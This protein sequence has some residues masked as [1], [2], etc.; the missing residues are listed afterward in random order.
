M[1]MQL[2]LDIYCSKKIKEVV[3]FVGYSQRNELLHFPLNY[4]SWIQCGRMSFIRFEVRSFHCFFYLKNNIKVRNTQRIITNI[5]HILIFIYF[6]R[7]R[8]VSN[9]S[10]DID[11]QFFLIRP[12][13]TQLHDCCC[14][15]LHQN[16]SLT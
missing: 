13:K 3:F 16:L 1:R 12:R 4:F 10:I 6:N 5:F 15:F 8:L 11:R 14:W 7:K 2:L 9:R